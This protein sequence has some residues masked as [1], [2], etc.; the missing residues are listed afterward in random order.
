[1][2]SKRVAGFQRQGS[3]RLRGGEEAKAAVVNA[4]PILPTLHVKAKA[5]DCEHAT[6]LDLVPI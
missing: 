4:V 1:M 6:V 5:T 2:V 3:H